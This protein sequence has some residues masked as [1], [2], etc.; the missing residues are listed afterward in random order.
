MPADGVP[1]LSTE[2]PVHQVVKIIPLGST[3]EQ[4]DISLPKARAG[5]QIG[6]RKIL[7]LVLQKHLG[8]QYCNSA[9]M[10]HGFALLDVSHTVRQ[11]VADYLLILVY[12]EGSADK[13]DQIGASG[14]SV[15]NK[16]YTK[17]SA[18]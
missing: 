2:F 15:F 1:R 5:P 8:L 11:D 9:F 12:G 10:L 13:G 17:N 7:R 14:V 6:I 16:L 4:K 18:R 3:L